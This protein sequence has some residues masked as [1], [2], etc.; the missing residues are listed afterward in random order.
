[1]FAKLSHCAYEQLELAIYALKI[2]LWLSSVHGS[3]IGIRVC[4]VNPRIDWLL[5]FWLSIIRGQSKLFSWLVF[6]DNGKNERDILKRL[7]RHQANFQQ[8]Q[9]SSEQAINRSV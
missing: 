2:L 4:V 9:H 6:N 7:W 3:T 8:Q 5:F 1:M